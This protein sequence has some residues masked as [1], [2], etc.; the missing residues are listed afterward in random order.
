MRAIRVYYSK[1]QLAGKPYKSELINKEN[2]EYL[3]PYKPGLL[4]N[5]HFSYFWGLKNKDINPLCFEYVDTNFVRQDEV[6]TPFTLGRVKAYHPTRITFY[7]DETF[8]GY[9][10]VLIGDE[11]ELRQTNYDCATERQIDNHILVTSP[12][13]IKRIELSFEAF[14][15]RERK[16][17]E[18]KAALQEKMKKIRKPL[19]VLFGIK[20][21]PYH[22]KE[23]Q[24]MMMYLE[25][26]GH[27]K[28]IDWKLEYEDVESCFEELLRARNLPVISENPKSDLF[29]QEAVAEIAKNIRCEPFQLIMLD[30]QT[31]GFYIA[32]LE[33]ETIVELKRI[34]NDVGFSLSTFA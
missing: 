3:N 14:Y 15:S 22:I 19:C 18:E 23:P 24:E 28:Y 32:L 27:F 17:I 10:I 25:R 12:D 11:C 34:I 31:D 33:E 29:G 21:I 1:Y 30:A 9:H 6:C 26:K 7:D 13:V 16:L 2:I 8:I 4:K 20:S 5:A